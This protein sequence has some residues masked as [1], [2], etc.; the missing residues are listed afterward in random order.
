MMIFDVLKEKGMTIIIVT[1]DMDVAKR[2]DSII[3]IADG[4]VVKDKSIV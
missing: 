3:E 1:H 4:C 2:C